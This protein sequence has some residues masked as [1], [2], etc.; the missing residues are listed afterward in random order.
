[1][2]API[3]AAP[4]P[5]RTRRLLLT[6]KQCVV[7]GGC[8]MAPP[9]NPSTTSN[10]VI[11]PRLGHLFGSSRDCPA[12]CPIYHMALSSPAVFD[13]HCRSSTFVERAHDQADSHHHRGRL[14]AVAILIVNSL[15]L[16]AEAGRLMSYG[17]N[18]VDAWRQAGSYAGRILKGANP[19]ELLAIRQI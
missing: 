7:G 1:M 16:H 6:L 8:D 14:I 9:N 19:A 10:A 18:I 11:A 13:T 12:V 5:R 4:T 3:A 2:P 15:D 17:A